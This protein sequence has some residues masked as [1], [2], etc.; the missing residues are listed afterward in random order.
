[1]SAV[2][3]P[4]FVELIYASTLDPTKFEA[5]LEHWVRC[6]GTSLAASEAFSTRQI[7]SHLRMAINLLEELDQSPSAV[8]D[9]AIATN[10]KGVIQNLGPTAR[11]LFGI[12]AGQ[13][14]QDLPLDAST[15]GEIQRTLR[16]RS[17]SRDPQNTRAIIGKRVPSGITM[18]LLLEPEPD[19]L[20]RITSSEIS[21][22]N[23]LSELMQRS[24]E[25]TGTEIEVVRQLVL[26]HT[27]EQ[28]AEIRSRSVATV[29]T[30]MRSIYAKTSVSSLPELVRMM[31]GV[32]SQLQNA[33]GTIV[34]SKPADDSYPREHQRRLL[35]LPD[36]RN[37]DYSV[38]GAPTGHPVL[39]MHDEICG[40]GWT[41]DAVAMAE[42]M[43]LRIIAPLRPHYGRSDP[44]LRGT[45]FPMRQTAEDSLYLLD[46]LGIDRATVLCK[47]LGGIPIL[48]LTEMAPERVT[49]VVSIS[50]PMPV[51]EQ[52][53]EKINPIT[54]MALLS[55]MANRPLFKFIL[56]VRRAILNRHGPET[57]LRKHFSHPSDQRLLDDPSI[58]AAIIHGSQITR[59]KGV[60]PYLSDVD[61]ET[62]SS[63]SAAAKLRVPVKFV[64]GEHDQNG[65][66][67]RIQA[68]LDEGVDGELIRLPNTCELAFFKQPAV[69]LELVR[70]FAL[71]G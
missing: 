48:Y 68:V 60:A 16:T 31:V 32:A 50:A 27:I 71:K 52:D 5:A 26:G 45:N 4:D 40:D 28:L 36:G 63:A 54:R 14:L 9:A 53:L 70:S 39:F 37:L 18:L 43:N 65:R 42:R 59:E 24:F 12:E 13:T 69:I 29:R 44:H 11:E 23:T 35:K 8:P 57:F 51:R 7:E 19:G 21:W 33:E 20:W 58:Y 55:V 3:E 34:S 41:A 56:R 1:M 15:L 10:A 67:S 61:T 22:S 6:V 46:Q 66:A 30:Q 2:D 17:D 47:I 49:G 62:E 38:F 25:L 64:I